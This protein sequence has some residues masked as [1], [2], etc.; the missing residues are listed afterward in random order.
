MQDRP[1]LPHGFLASTELD[2]TPFYNPP[3]K[4]PE[5]CIGFPAQCGQSRYSRSGQAGRV[6]ALHTGPAIV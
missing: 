5:R 6:A 4:D 1:G 3:I 2:L